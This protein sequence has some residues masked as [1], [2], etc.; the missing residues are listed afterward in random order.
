MEKGKRNFVFTVGLFHTHLPP[1]PAMQ[2]CQSHAAS[3]R[4]GLQLPSSLFQRQRGAAA[5]HI[6]WECLW[7]CNISPRHA[8]PACPSTVMYRHQ[9]CSLPIHL[10]LRPAFGEWQPPHPL[11]SSCRSLERRCEGS[12]LCFLGHRH[13]WTQL[14]HLPPYEHALCALSLSVY[15]LDLLFLESYSCVRVWMS[16]GRGR[17]GREG[18]QTSDSCVC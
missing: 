18:K 8:L 4:K 14:C 12:S 7:I 10:K 9:A 16:M 1:T 17:K 3:C 6:S 11:L 15:I 2:C 5:L 13:I